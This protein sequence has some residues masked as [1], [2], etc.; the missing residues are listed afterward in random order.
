MDTQPEN[1]VPESPETTPLESTE[2]LSPQGIAAMQGD[3]TNTPVDLPVETNPDIAPP[4]NDSD[5]PPGYGPTSPNIKE[6]SESKIET[7]K[8]PEAEQRSPIES[9]TEK[10]G[11]LKYQPTGHGPESGG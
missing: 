7:R 9:E 4:P 5:A 10:R 11:S 3:D 1:D 2:K 8:N 6:S